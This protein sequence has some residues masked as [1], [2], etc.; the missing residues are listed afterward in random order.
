MREASGLVDA[1]GNAVAAVAYDD[2]SRNSVTLG[3]KEAASPVRLRNVADAQTDTDAVNLKQLRNAGL[4]DGEGATLDAV[5]Y[6]GDSSKG[7]VTFGGA[8]GT[9]LTNVADGRI[10]T[11]S[12][13][14][15]NGGQVAALRDSFNSSINGLNSRVTTLENEPAASGSN[16]SNP[17]VNVQGPGSDANSGVTAAGSVAI[18]ASTR[19]QTAG[20]VAVGDGAQVTSEAAGSVAIGSGSV[21]DR[22]NSVSVGASGSERVVANVADGVRDTDVATVRQMNQAQSAQPVRSCRRPSARTWRSCEKSKPA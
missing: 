13:D 12:R 22:P 11:G 17:L 10:A 21:A 1:D 15:V 8:N 7:R 16:S 18:G 4:V 20:G 14:A 9:V 5:V 2:A 6:D 19:V 3:G